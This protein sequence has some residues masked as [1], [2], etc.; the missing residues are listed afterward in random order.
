MSEHG[1]LAEDLVADI[2]R[3]MFLADFTVRNPQLEKES[4]IEKEVADALV[5]FGG[6]LI[7]FQVKSKRS[8][9]AAESDPEIYRQRVQK[10]VSKGIDQL[11]T[12]KRAVKAGQIKV[13]KN[14]AGV[15]LHS[16]PPP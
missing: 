14:A 12:I 13:V 10:T 2:C 7:A 11:K 15:E 6:V 3:T 8:S 9:D 5:P 4:G 16:I 1:R